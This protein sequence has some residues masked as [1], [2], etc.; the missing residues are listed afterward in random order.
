M[1]DIAMLTIKELLPLLRFGPHGE[2]DSCE[3]LCV[4]A[5]GITTPISTDNQLDIAAYGDF[6]VNYLFVDKYGLEI[7][8]KT[9]FCK[10]GA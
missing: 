7:G 4:A 5:D 1:E 6:I 8:I 2:E 10:A 9:E 3:K